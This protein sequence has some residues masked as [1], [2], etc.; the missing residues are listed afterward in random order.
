MHADL[1]HALTRIFSPT[2]SNTTSGGAHSAYQSHP[3]ARIQVGDG[4]L[5][6][7]AAA[8]AESAGGNA[9]SPAAKPPLGR[10]LSSATLKFRASQAAKTPK[11][12]ATPPPPAAAED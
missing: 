2:R 7:P 9:A 8:D 6:P 4:R 10:S 11:A 1:V 5:D 12:D 3:P